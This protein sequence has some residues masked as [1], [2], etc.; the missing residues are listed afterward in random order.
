MIDPV[1]RATVCARI[2]DAGRRGR[3]GNSGSATGP[4][5][6]WRSGAARRPQTGVGVA[7]SVIYSSPASAIVLRWVPPSIDIASPVT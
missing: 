5:R 7:G 6:T 1:A 4:F 3:K 2:V